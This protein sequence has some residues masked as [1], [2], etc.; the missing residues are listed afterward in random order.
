MPLLERFH[1][2]NAAEGWQV[3]GV[4]VDREPQVLDFVRQHAI[5]FPIALA[6]AVGLDL[7]RDLGNGPG[8]LPF[9]VAFAKVGSPLGTRLGPVDEERL[10]SWTEAARAAR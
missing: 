3:L 8:G 4:A 2:E 9:T 10:R 7:A 6:G 5:S 1:R